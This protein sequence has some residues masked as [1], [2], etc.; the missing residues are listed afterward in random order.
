MDEILDAA[1][2]VFERDGVRDGSMSAI[3]KSAGIGRAT[4]YRYYPG[5]DALL[6]A[7][8]LREARE[9]FALLD[10]EL[11]GSDDLRS[12]LDRGLLR[13][14]AYLRSH[15]LLQRVLREEPESILPLLTVDAAPLLNA[16]VDFA[17]PYIER[18]V[19][20]ERITAVDPRAAA[21]WAARILLS[22]LLTPSV[23]V[24]L[25]EPDQRDAFVGWITEK[26]ETQGGRS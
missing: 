22:L 21:E 2:S 7:F 13:A 6:T 25:D 12:L 9:L 3:A 8:V 20:A 24:D 5:K 11:G 14:L 19:K 23:T 1:R 15:T 10:E 4:L 26:I 16:A 17:T 18:A